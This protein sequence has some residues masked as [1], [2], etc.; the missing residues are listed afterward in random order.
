MVSCVARRGLSNISRSY[1]FFAY[2]TIEKHIKMDKKICFFV[3]GKLLFLLAENA[4]ETAWGTALFLRGCHCG[5][6][7]LR[8]HCEHLATASK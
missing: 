1:F 7:C 3:A 6:G 8:G 4:G 5:W 2:Y